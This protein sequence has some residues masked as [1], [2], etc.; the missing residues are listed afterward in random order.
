MYYNYHGRNLQR[1][2]NGELVAVEKSERTEFAFVLVFSTHPFFRPIRPHAVW[3]Y[4]KTLAMYDG[5][6]KLK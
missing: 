6:P 3:R 5:I 4:E 2:E 1:I